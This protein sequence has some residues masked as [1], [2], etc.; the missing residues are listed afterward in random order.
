MPYNHEEKIHNCKGKHICEGKCFLFPFS[1]EKT[2]ESKCQLDYGHKGNHL[3]KILPENHKCNKKCSSKECNKKCTLNANHEEKY[4]LCGECKCNIEDCQYKNISRNCQKKCRKNFKHEGPHQCEENN[5]LCIEDCN[6]KN[7]TKKENGG[8]KGKC[9]LPAGHEGDI[10]FCENPKE[11]HKCPGKCSLRQ[12]SSSK[13]CNIFCDK[14]IDHKS[15]CICNIEI[16]KH[17][18]KRECELKKIK[19]C[20][21]SCCLPVYHDN[22]GCICSVG[23]ERH[24][25]NKKCSLYDKSKIGCNHFCVLTYDHKGPCFCSAEKEVHKCN[26]ICILLNESKA[27]CLKD[28]KFSANH[29]GDCLCQNSE[30]DHIC[31]GICSLK[32]NSRAETCYDQCSLST[33]HKGKC[34]CY[35]KKHICSKDCDYRD[36]SRTGCFGRCMKDTDHEGIHICENELNK[37]K[38]KEKCYLASKSRLGCNQF[39]DKIPGHEGNCLCDSKLK[40]LCNNYCYLLNICHKDNLRYCCKNAEHTDID[41]NDKHDC[42]EENEH[43]CN[44]QCKLKNITIGCETECSLPYNHE[45]LY[46]TEC[47]CKKPKEQHLCLEKCELCTNIQKPCEFEYNHIENGKEHHLCGKEHKCLKLCEHE[48][49]CEIVTNYELSKKRVHVLL[50]NKEKI[51]FEEKSEQISRRL[52]CNIDISPKKIDHKQKG[53]HICEILIHKCGFQCK[54]CNRL[55]NL[56]FGH[57]VAHDCDHGLIDNAV[58][59]TEGEYA[60]LNYLN[61]IYDF[62]N[63]ESANI[64]T[65]YQYCKEQGRGHIHI[66]DES[67]LEEKEKEF[68]GIYLEKKYI[69]LN[70]NNLY[71]CKC[72]FFWEKVLKFNFEDKFDDDKK[73]IFN[74]CP[75]ECPLCQ[76]SERKSYCN[77]DLWHEQLSNVINK[78]KDNFW[79]S[80]EGH[81]FTCSHPMPCH[82][83]FIVDK[84]G[85]M[86]YTDIKPSLQCIIENNNF[87]NRFGR[88]IENM[89]N[90]I[91]KRKNI[92]PE[93]IFSLVSFSDEASIIFQ[94]NSCDLNDPNFNFIQECMQKI[95]KCQG[96]T[97]FNLGF[98][99]AEKIL[100]E[101]NREKYKPVIILFSDGADQKQEETIEIVERVSIYSINNIIFTNLDDE[102]E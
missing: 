34:I 49:I 98:I 32:I 29:Q 47:I 78:N 27:G 33:R 59:F 35:S 39:C 28:C 70:K 87:N 90:Y 93:D 60:K 7:R 25:C 57:K 36:K 16:E 5:H 11:K 100:K 2:C 56:E 89:Y 95:N 82:T 53:K 58:I 13:S 22:R 73:K 10:H 18:C 72:Q 44:K 38:C 17:I 52:K 97:E 20:N 69:R 91:K 83:I 80:K 64:F 3:C 99:E 31:N 21:I 81:K 75:A 9:K 26:K 62:E 23:K 48:G 61:K 77:E 1:K 71:E 14:S 50:K 79:I 92:S 66:I 6:F 8:C 55:C 85:S 15:P 63:E 37:H 102:N 86:S 30:K 67:K 4:C 96:E 65:C 41:K 45:K 46:N 19:G 84:S 12:E 94:N 74:K 88:L 43:K 40:H 51:V 76:T 101:I 68:I 42:L 54:Q 24:L